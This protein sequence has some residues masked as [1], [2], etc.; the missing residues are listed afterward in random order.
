[1]HEFSTTQQI[2]NCILEEAKKRNA[3]KVTD[4]NL[5]IGKLT[6]LGLEQIKFC[7]SLLVKDTIME[8]S[9]LRI[10]Q[11]EPIVECEKCSYKG[12]IKH[13]NSDIFHFMLP[14]LEC[15]K[16]GGTVSIVKGRE[17]IVKNFKMVA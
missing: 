6:V 5:L 1:M 17:C 12:P 8:N 7:Y 3:K 9:K 4:V 16:C 14:V 11:V 10:E 15:P 2:V 13:E